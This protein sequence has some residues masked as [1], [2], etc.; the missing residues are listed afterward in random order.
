MT[1]APESVLSERDF[2]WEK[3]NALYNAIT[4]N[5]LL[6]AASFRQAVGVAG[7]IFAQKGVSIQHSTGWFEALAN[8]LEMVEKGREQKVGPKC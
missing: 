4:Q 5:G 6:T 2:L 7:N 3:C 8:F 1:E